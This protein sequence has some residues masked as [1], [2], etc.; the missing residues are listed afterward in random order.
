MLNWLMPASQSDR[1]RSGVSMRAVRDQ[2]D[3]LE[4][5]RAIDFGDEVLEVAAQRRLAAGERDE[6]RIEEAR[7]VGVALELRSRAARDRS[8]SSRRSR[9]ARCSAA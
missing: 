6:H 4:A 9:S 2:R 7:G 5:D 1:A 8:S 3:V